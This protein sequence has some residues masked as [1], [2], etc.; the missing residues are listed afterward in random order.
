M[1]SRRWAPLCC[2]VLLAVYLADLTLRPGGVDLTRSIDDIA[3]MLAA[4]VAAVAAL[5]RGLHSRGRTRTS[6]L[7]IAGGTGGWAVGEAIW[8][9]YEVLIGRETPF[10][11]LADVGFLLFPILGLAGLLVRPSAAFAGQGRIRVT[12][13]AVLIAASLLIVSWGTA[14]GE[15]YRVGGD[16]TFA[17]VVSLAYPGSDLVL[18]TVTVVVVSYARTGARRGLWWITAGLVALSVG[19]S[20]FAYLT[21]TD[22]YSGVNLVDGGWVAGFLILAG[23]AI[24]DDVADVPTQ[25]PVAPRVALLMPYVPA[26]LAVLVLLRQASGHGALDVVLTTAGAFLAV[27]LIGRQMLVLL[28]NRALMSRVSHQA[29]HDVLTGLANRALF[30]DRLYHALDL[31]RRDLRPIAVLLIDIDDFKTVNDSLGHPAGDELL[32]RISE[33]LCASVRTG[34]T[35]ARLGGDEFAVLLE[36]G[37]DAYDVAARLLTSLDLPVSLCGRELPVRAS[38]GVAL[39]SAGD[40]AT[41]GTEMLKRADVAMYAAKR[42]GKGTVMTYSPALAGGDA[43]QLDLHAALVSAVAAGD[44]DVAFQPIRLADG[45]LRGFEALARWSYDGESVSPMVF[46]P[47]A[48]RLGLLPALDTGVVRRAVREAAKWPT[49]I[50]LSVNLGVESLTDPALPARISQALTEAGVAP[51]RLSIE[52]LESSVIEQDR[53]AL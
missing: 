42:A 18:L 28:E 8:T 24:L 47:L 14:L 15:V 23:A 51:E 22:N 3:E 52:V 34:D 48:R 13:D 33:R 2:A 30:T 29:F 6:W 46:I 49:D 1:R 27:A 32:V 16:S 26:A 17:A 38:I 37:G 53:R 19:D 39:L 20:G 31:H 50:A 44:I 35:V 41:D 4:A 45:T 11:S 25:T 12:L 5:W 7:L 9:Y 36:D 21:A 40:P 43:E 10:P